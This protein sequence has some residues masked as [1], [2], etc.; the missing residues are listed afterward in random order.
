META[1]ERICNA[2]DYALNGRAKSIGGIGMGHGSI[3]IT[4]N[5]GHI[6][7]DYERSEIA[8]LLGGGHVVS[9]PGGVLIGSQ[10]GISIAA[11][12]TPL[13]P[14]VNPESGLTIQP[15]A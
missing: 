3:I 2:I 13:P 14:H 4:V 15:L 5:N 10:P 9:F 11:P 6:A 8:A 7:D 12:N 1:L